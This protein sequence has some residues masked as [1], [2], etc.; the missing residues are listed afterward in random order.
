MPAA[1]AKVTA[2]LG[3]WDWFGEMNSGPS[4]PAD[5]RVPLSGHHT[6]TDLPGH[7]PVTDTLRRILA[8]TQDRMESATEN[9]PA[10][11]PAQRPARRAAKATKAKVAISKTIAPEVTALKNRRT[12]LSDQLKPH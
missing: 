4:T 2:V 6:N 5:R 12:T 11:P 8:E 1:F 9:E 3:E 7:L 10:S